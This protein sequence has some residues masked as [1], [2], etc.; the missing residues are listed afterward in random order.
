M[1]IAI[2]ISSTIDGS[3]KTTVACMFAQLLSSNYKVLAIDLSGQ[4]NLTETLIK[5]QNYN[6]ETN[7]I[8]DAFETYDV[9]PYI[10]STTENLHILPGDMW[11]GSIPSYLYSQ[12]KN[13]TEIVIILRDLLNQAKKDYDFVVIDSPSTSAQELFDLSLSIS[14][15]AIMTYSPNK[16]N[17]INQW[18]NR[19][20]HVQNNFNPDLRVG[21]ILRTGINK[22][23]ALHKYSNQEV[24]KHYPWLC[25]KNVFSIDPLFAN[26]DIYGNKKKRTV[27][28]FTAIY[29]ELILRLLN[30]HKGSE[31]W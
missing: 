9:A 28:A 26:L 8:C 30:S 7:T 13:E 29:D 27:S 4:C 10:V 20:N 6:T 24:L 16:L 18:L 5:N 12:G 2:C 14:D 23:E 15:F 21:G 17:L 1:T 19:I 25:W 31:V 3:Y 22:I 11:I